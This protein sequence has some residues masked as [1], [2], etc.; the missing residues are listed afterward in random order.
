[1]VKCPDCK[2][3]I[4][5]TNLWVGKFGCIYCASECNDCGVLTK[6]TDLHPTDKHTK[7]C[8]PCFKK[9]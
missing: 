7:I 3:E 2:Q 5:K 1:M 8:V 4:D 6:D 9:R